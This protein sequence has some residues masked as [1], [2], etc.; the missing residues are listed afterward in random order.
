ME[1]AVFLDRDG[2]I[3][4]NKRPVNQPDDLKLYPGVGDAI[5]RLNDDGYIVFVVTNQGGVGLGYLSVQDLE[6]IH[7][8]MMTELSKEGAHI[9]E[10]RACI[11]KPHE[12]CTCR[13]PDS[14]ML[15]DL[16]KKYNVDLSN[17][18]MIGDRITDIEAGQKAG[19]KTI[20]LGE[21]H[22]DADYTT[23]NLEKAANWILKKES[24][25]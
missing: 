12:G 9:H 24:T 18:Y 6:N 10:I 5:R 8:Y 15:T 23:D 16:A 22:V 3:N 1:R 19:T 21:K 20:F 4:D 2:V 7:H 14:G 25:H 17:S 11:H 13:K